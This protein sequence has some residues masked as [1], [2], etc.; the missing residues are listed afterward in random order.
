MVDMADI[1]PPCGVTTWWR[2]GHRRPAPKGRRAVIVPIPKAGKDPK[3]VGSHRPIALTSHVA[4][5][6]ERL[7]AA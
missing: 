6:A 5:L 1:E 4:K 3:L 7:V 2:I